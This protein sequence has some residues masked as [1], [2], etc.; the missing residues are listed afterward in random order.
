MIGFDLDYT[1]ASYNS[2]MQELVFELAR[3]YLVNI[4]NY[5]STFL[6]AQY[7]PSFAVRGIART[8]ALTYLVCSTANHGRA[9]ISY[10]V[11]HGLL[12]KM[13]YHDNV[14]P[15]C[16]F[17]GKTLLSNAEVRKIYNGMYVSRVYRET[18]MKALI[19][20]FSMSEACLIASLIQHFRDNQ[21]EFSNRAVAEV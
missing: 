12:V 3:D 19:D 21:T 5:P 15:N 1:L 20:M 17:R 11:N 7:D 4:L 16:V 10:D 14:T 18:N 13:D 8:S 6:T 9:G 2:R